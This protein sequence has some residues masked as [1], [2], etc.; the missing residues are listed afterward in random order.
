MDIVVA[1][2]MAT[3][4]GY[5]LLDEEWKGVKYKY[6][7]LSYYGFE[8]LCSFDNFKR[9]KRCPKDKVV[10]FFM[11]VIKP[12]FEVREYEILLD[13][14][15]YID[16][17][18]MFYFRCNLGIL[19]ETCWNT[20]SRG[21][22]NTF[23]KKYN[24]YK[25][26]KDYISDKRGRILQPWYEYKGVDSPVR[27]RCSNGHTSFISLSDARSGHW[28]DKCFKLEH[29]R[30]N[31][32]KNDIALYSTLSPKLN[33]YGEKTKV[34]IKDSIELLGVYCKE[35]AKLYHPGRRKAYERLSALQFKRRGNSYFYCSDKCKQDNLYY[36][37]LK[38][39]SFEK[40]I[41]DYVNTFFKGTIK[42]NDRSILKN[43]KTDK[44]L[45]LDFYFPEY[46]KAIECNGTYW[47]SKESVIK[48]D[49][50]KN[51]L[52]NKYNINLLVLPEE[53][54]YSYKDNQ[55]DIIYKFITFN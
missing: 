22:F 8:W 21:T 6:T 27:Y 40:E 47:H 33:H 44:Y 41:N 23:D 35:C 7:F 34:I 51:E 45:E 30:L 46:N 10:E 55:K 43:P 36:N 54:W 17:F 37:S 14:K 42:R 19:Y 9:G 52:C 12:E 1:K 31:I 53:L 48:R 26:L 32:N 24:S 38:E 3:S 18:Q 49:K 39:S 5:T 28:C 2:I 11:Y 20:V 4:Y 15:D 29:S 13:P 50:I 25:E 16:Q